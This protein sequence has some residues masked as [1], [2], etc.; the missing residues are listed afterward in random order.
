MSAAEDLSRHAGHRSCNSGGRESQFLWVLQTEF[1]IPRFSIELAFF[2]FEQLQRKDDIQVLSILESVAFA[3]K[4]GKR[5][6]NGSHL[7]V[8]KKIGEFTVQTP[9]V[10][11]ALRR[12]MFWILRK[13]PASHY[14]GPTCVFG[15][16]IFEVTLSA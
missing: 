9:S 2:R 6:Q 1:W 8:M 14:F 10:I 11:M 5:D 16:K 12:G 7:E 15:P 13:N 3:V 4:T